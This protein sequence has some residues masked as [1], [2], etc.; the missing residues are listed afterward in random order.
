MKLEHHG[1]GRQRDRWLVDALI[2]AAARHGGQLTEDAR[3]E[4]VAEVHQNNPSRKRALAIV[5]KKLRNPN[6]R[7]A[8]ADVYQGVADFTI[9]DAVEL[10]VGHIRGLR[11]RAIYKDG[12]ERDVIEKPSWPALKAY[13]DLVFPQPIDHKRA[14]EILG[15]SSPMTTLVTYAHVLPGIGGAAVD[16]IADRL[17]RAESGAS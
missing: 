5:D 8:L 14:A 7:Q 10:H 12:S 3:H 13:E 11:H 2:R 16:A 6:I 4:A 15:H 17:D 1:I 9:G